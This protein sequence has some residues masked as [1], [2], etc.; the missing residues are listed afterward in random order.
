MSKYRMLLKPL[1]G[2][3]VWTSG[4]VASAW[5]VPQA[6]SSFGLVYS[7]GQYTVLPVLIEMNNSVK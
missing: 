5:A 1:K 4:G 6:L 2:A 3:V 7:S